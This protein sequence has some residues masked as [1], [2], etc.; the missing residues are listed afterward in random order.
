MI[1]LPALSLVESSFRFFLIPINKY[2]VAPVY[3]FKHIYINP[4][5]HQDSDAFITELQAQ[6]LDA[7]YQNS[8]DSIMLESQY[9]DIS[10]TQVARLFGRKFAK[11]LN[12]LILNQWQDPVK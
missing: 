3:N 10:A 11:Q 4:E 6:N 8:G 9:I 12:N 2:T 5:Q 7:I 1:P